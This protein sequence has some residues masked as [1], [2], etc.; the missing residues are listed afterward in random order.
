MLSILKAASRCIV[1]FLAVSITVVS[2]TPTPARTVSA[3]VFVTPDF[4]RTKVHFV[5][6]SGLGSFA[7][8]SLNGLTG[9]ITYYSYNQETVKIWTGW[10]N[11]GNPPSP[12]NGGTVVAYLSMRFPSVA[13]RFS[14]TTQNSSISYPRL[15]PKKLYSIDVWDVTNSPSEVMLEQVGPPKQGSLSFASPLTNYQGYSSEVL[16]L[17]LVANPTPSG[18]TF[19]PPSV[20]FKKGDKNPQNVTAEYG[21]TYDQNTQLIGNTCGVGSKLIATVQQGFDYGFWTITPGSKNGRCNFTIQDIT[22]PQVQGTE[23]VTNNS[24]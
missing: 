3:P 21:S 22:N 8:P 13:P 15:D 7:V 6:L 20:T 14:G 1:G 4:T 17:E 11:Y 16:D 19:V 23:Y 10:G 12:S 9:T 18:I 24:N 2:A 5:R